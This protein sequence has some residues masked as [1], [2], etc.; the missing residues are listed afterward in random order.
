MQFWYQID[1]GLI[2]WIEKHHMY[3]MNS[4]MD[5]KKRAPHFVTFQNQPQFYFCNFTFTHLTQ[6]NGENISSQCNCTQLKKA[7]F[8]SFRREEK[9]MDIRKG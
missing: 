1:A 2:E 6:R 7:M 4:Q 5:N 3:M 8:N 9:D